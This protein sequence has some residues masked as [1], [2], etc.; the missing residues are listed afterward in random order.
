MSDPFTGQ[1]SI[2]GFNF[3]PYNWAPCNGQLLPISRYSALFSLIGTTF[4][5][6][7][8]STFAL[9]N[10]GSQ[11][12]V[13][14]GPMAGGQQYDMGEVGGGAAVALN[15]IQGPIHIHALMANAVAATSNDAKGN[16]LAQPDGPGSPKHAAGL[17]YS[18]KAQNT[19]LTSPVG[20]AGN[21]QPHPNL[22]PV[23]ALNYCICLTGIMPNRPT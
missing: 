13:G 15:S 10:M 17:I 14:Q 12:A 21:S 6:N 16:V 9:P 1:I 3:A 23:L 19:A 4:G 22:Q 20:P 18:P 11:V 5:G 2:F 8:T 7:G